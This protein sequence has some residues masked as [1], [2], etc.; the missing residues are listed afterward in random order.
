MTQ[1]A[2]EIREPNLRLT[3]PLMEEIR[4]YWNDHIHDLELAKHPVGTKGFFDDLDTY[5]FDKLRYLPR[6]VNFKGYKSKKFLEVGCGVGIDLVRFAKG[7]AIVTGVDLADRSIELAKRNFQHHGIT[8][9]LILGNGED[10][11]IEDNSFDVVYAHGVIQY[12]A[13]DQA[14]VDELYRVVKPG[15]EV[16]MM[17]YNRLSWL[18]FLSV[19][20]GVALEHEDA[21]VLKKYSI[22]EFKELLKKFPKVKIIPERF[23]VKSRL[24]KGVKAMFFNGVFVPIFNLIPRFIT[25]RSGWHLLAFAY[26]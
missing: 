21:P 11:V 6:L 13:N 4:K 8:G 9:H 19:T 18:N 25:R 5:R 12:T 20:L 3:D 22:K 23:P 17:V 26:K 16:I 24:Q 2:V 1:T 7:G 10:L 15:G 14:M